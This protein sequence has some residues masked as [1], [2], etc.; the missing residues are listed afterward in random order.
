LIVVLHHGKVL[1]MGS[2]KE[3]ITLG[4]HYAALHTTLKS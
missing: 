4:K 2:H 3:L 1:E